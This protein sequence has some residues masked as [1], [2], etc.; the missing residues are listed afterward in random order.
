MH[1]AQHQRRTKPVRPRGSLVERHLG[2]GE[3]LEEMPEPAELCVVNSGSDPS[4]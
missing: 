3:R 4:A 1:T 2:S